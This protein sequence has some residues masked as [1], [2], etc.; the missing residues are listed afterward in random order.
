[1]PAT[2]ART[3]APTVRNAIVPRS[4]GDNPRARIKTA[5]KNP[6]LATMLPR[7][8]TAP[9]VATAFS[10]EA[11]RVPPDTDPS[12][13]G[14]EPASAPAPALSSGAVPRLI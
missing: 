9:P 6:M 4:D 11:R 10:Q 12:E 13:P 8:S 2:R 5:T 14:S 7:K 3:W 1:M